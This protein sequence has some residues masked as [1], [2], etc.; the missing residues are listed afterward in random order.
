LHLYLTSSHSETQ[1]LEIGDR[2]QVSSHMIYAHSH[3]A[4]IAFALRSG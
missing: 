1:L 4:T 3:R 2:L